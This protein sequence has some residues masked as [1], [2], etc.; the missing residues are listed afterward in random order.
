MARAAAIVGLCVLLGGALWLMVAGWNSAG[1]VEISGQGY[2][3]LILGV[4]FSLVVGGGLMALAF[5]SSRHG[6]DEPAR[7]VLE[8]EEDRSTAE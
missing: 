3:A 6:Y 1:D 4:A 2:A 7:R 5:Y 8:S